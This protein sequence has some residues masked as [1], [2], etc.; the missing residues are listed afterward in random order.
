MLGFLESLE[1]LVVCLF[2]RL[3]CPEE[4]QAGLMICFYAPFPW[5]LFFPEFSYCGC[6]DW[7]W[8]WWWVPVWTWGVFHIRLFRS[9]PMTP[10]SGLKSVNCCN[11]VCALV[12]VFGSSLDGAQREES[13]GQDGCQWRCASG[14]RVPAVARYAYIF[15]LSLCPLYLASPYFLSLSL[16]EID[17]PFF[18]LVPSA[19]EAWRGSQIASQMTY[20][21]C[22]HIRIERYHKHCSSRLCC[23][24][25][26]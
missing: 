10:S 22:L 26:D 7:W 12:Y 15:S 8:W 14:V 16:H 17:H 11:G 18:S 19:P 3:G 1:L 24:E 2:F 23:S 6:R 20:S 21:S 25:G 4:K 13:V 9:D 5:D